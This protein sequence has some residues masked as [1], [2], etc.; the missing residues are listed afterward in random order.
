MPAPLIDKEPLTPGT[1]EWCGIDCEPHR[2]ACSLTCEANLHR[3]EATQ[4]RMVIRQLKR[5]RMKPSHAARNS[6]IAEIVPLIDRFMRNDRKRREIE[7]E[8][9]RKAAA[10]AAEK[11]KAESMAEMRAAADKQA[12]DAEKRAGKET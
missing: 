5:W 10:E 12:A 11:A 8:L 4:G 6:A 9:R 2:V 1:C 3:Q 7:N